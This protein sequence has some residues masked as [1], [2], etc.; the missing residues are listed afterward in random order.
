MESDL[1]S[2]DFDK[3]FKKVMKFELLAIN[4]I[5]AICDKSK[6]IFTKEP[7]I[8]EIS[9]PITLIGDIHGQFQDLMEIFYQQG[10]PKDG[11]SFI[12]IGDYVDRGLNSVEVLLILLL[13]KIQYPNQVY[14]TRGNHESRMIT[15]QY[16]FYDE[17]LRKY[18]SSVV[19]QYFT[20]VFDTIPLGGLINNKIYCLHGGLSPS[21]NKIDDI[22]KV[23]RFSDIP[24]NGLSCDMLWSDQEDIKGWG[25][26]SRWARYTWGYDCS[27][28]F[29]YINNL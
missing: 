7:T 9:P 2:E 20:E 14:M 6:E 13:L 29:L 22:K 10:Y 1:E 11:I 8:L 18:G 26:N 5:K 4:E 24:R 17:I 3:M 12:F 21:N 16:G 28:K 23:E 27:E 19:W 25:I 15:Q